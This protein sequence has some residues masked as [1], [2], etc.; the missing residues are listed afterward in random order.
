[1]MST[2][3]DVMNGSEKA[4]LLLPKRFM[5]PDVRRILDSAEE[6]RLRIGQPLIVT[7]G[8][9]EIVV[10][11]DRIKEEDLYYS[12]EAASGSSLHTAALS[13]SNGFVSFRGIRVG[14]CG[15]FSKHENG[16]LSFRSLSSL[17]VRIPRECR[18]ICD[19][20]F[21]KVKDDKKGNVIVL[22]PPGGGKTTLIR[23]LVRLFSTSGKRIALVDERMEI[24]A[25]E[26]GEPQYDLGMHCDIISGVDKRHAAIMLLR[27]MNPQM[28]AVDEIT[29]ESDIE[30]VSQMIGCGVRLLAS[31]HASDLEDLCSRALYRRLTQDKVFRHAV[32]IRCRDGKRYYELKELCG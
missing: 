5:T 25:A 2:G 27:G 4:C 1:M 21:E 7:A 14:V 17:A 15:T 23:E 28:I 13:L 32:V 3:S 19:T 6:L 30:A 31:A 16:K 12:L 18:G 29:E 24:A 26:R 22:S 20:W 8:G 10:S 11:D 9:R